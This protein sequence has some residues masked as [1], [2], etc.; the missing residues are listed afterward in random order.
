MYQWVLF[1]HILA[2]FGFAMTH[3]ASAIVAFRLRRETNPERIVAL[4]D[5]S[6]S[7]FSWMYISLLI[8]LLGGITLGF[9]G[10]W[11]GQI[12]IWLVLVV[13]VAK[14]AAMS[15]MG[16]RSFAKVRKAAGLPY[17]EG[18]KSQPAI[19]PASPEEIAKVAATVNPLPIAIVGYGGLVVMLWLMAFKPF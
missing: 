14:F 4:L 8:I 12:W 13:I 19:P 7:V 9:L 5:L 18:T 10:E 11:W 2:A 6:S 15:M 3:G 16:A 1:I 17:F